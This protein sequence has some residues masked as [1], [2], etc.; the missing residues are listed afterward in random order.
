MAEF[1]KKNAGGM[2]IREGKKG[3]FLS[4]VFEPEG[5]EGPRFQFMAFKNDYKEEGSKQPDYKI[6]VSEDDEERPRDEKTSRNRAK[7]EPDIPF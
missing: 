2:W 3:K 4:G 1:K 6:V 5:R 7:D